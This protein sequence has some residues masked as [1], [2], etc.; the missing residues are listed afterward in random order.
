M[1]TALTYQV[2]ISNLHVIGI[3]HLRVLAVQALVQNP[4]DIVPVN[5]PENE[6]LFWR[7]I[8]GHGGDSGF[9]TATPYAKRLAK[10][11]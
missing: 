7:E 2:G 4:R 1:L 3:Q 9:Y 11:P 5:N 8:L 6:S 10:Q